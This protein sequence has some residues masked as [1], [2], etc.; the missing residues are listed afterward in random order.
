MIKVVAMALAIL[1]LLASPAAS[2]SSPRTRSLFLVHA[3]G[4]VPIP[5]PVHPVQDQQ[6]VHEEDYGVYDPVPVVKGCRH[7]PVPHAR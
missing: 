4:Q 7:A 5:P 6:R 2:S 3:D 1:L